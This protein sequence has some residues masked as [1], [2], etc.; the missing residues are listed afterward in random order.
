MDEGSPLSSP[1]GRNY[2]Q[3]DP[4]PEVAFTPLLPHI[5]CPVNEV[6]NQAA[7]E[8]VDEAVEQPV[9]SECDVFPCAIHFKQARVWIHI[10]PNLDHNCYPQMSIY[11]VE[12]QKG[13]LDAR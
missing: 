9:E 2:G 10:E 1:A 3:P 13:F 7:G 4:L 6:V 8:P 12:L 5:N 11:V